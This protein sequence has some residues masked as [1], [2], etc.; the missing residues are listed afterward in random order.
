MP[1]SLQVGLGSQ[2]A[3]YSVQAIDRIQPHQRQP[4][5]SS[6]GTPTYNLPITTVALYTL[7]VGESLIATIMEETE[8]TVE[9]IRVVT[10]DVTTV[11]KEA[12]GR[13]P[14]ET[15]TGI[16]YL[17]KDEQ[18]VRHVNSAITS[19]QESKRLCIRSYVQVVDRD[20]DPTRPRLNTVEADRSERRSVTLEIWDL[21]QRQVNASLPVLIDTG[22]DVSYV[23]PSVARS[24]AREVIPHPHPYN[25]IGDGHADFGFGDHVET[26][27]FD[28]LDLGGMHVVLGKNWLQVP[29]ACSQSA[30]RLKKPFVADVG[31]HHE[32]HP[33]H[34]SP[35]R[36]NKKTKR[37]MVMRQRE[38]VVHVVDDIKEHHDEHD[39]YFATYIYPA[40]TVFANVQKQE[41]TVVHERKVEIPPEYADLAAAFSDGNEELP[42]HGD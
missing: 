19:Y 3:Y 18:G 31:Q 32:P 40:S 1:G 14:M 13:R 33:G 22:A 15:P 21:S 37:I 25:P 39:M 41:E 2:K 36:N 30:E 20:F 28:I 6:G 23:S 35:P 17:W 27:K 26:F 8:E 42:E 9:T 12:V 5:S 7:L 11:D 29:R 4:H 38:A 10:Q 24:Y 16:L 34:I